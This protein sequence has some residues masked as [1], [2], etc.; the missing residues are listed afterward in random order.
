VWKSID[1]ATVIVFINLSCVTRWNGEM[2][3]DWSVSDLDIKS[4]RCGKSAAERQNWMFYERPFWP[5]Y[6]TPV[7]TEFIEHW[8]AYGSLKWAAALQLSSAFSGH[9][10]TTEN[11]QQ[12][13]IFILKWR[14][15]RP[16]NWF[17]RTSNSANLIFIAQTKKCKNCLIWLE[18]K[19][20]LCS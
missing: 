8:Y 16:N 17:L 9:R 19:I 3:A 20:F 2:A 18:I 12:T 13:F 4:K 14:L 6:L 10:I 11:Y 7:R 15:T 1:T 5:F